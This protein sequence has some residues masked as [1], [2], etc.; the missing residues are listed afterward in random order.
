MK[1]IEQEAGQEGVERYMGEWNAG[2]FDGWGFFKEGDGGKYLGQF[3]N[4]RRHGMGLMV[5]D[6]AKTKNAMRNSN[7]KL[8][9]WEHDKE[10]V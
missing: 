5:Q 10:I 8:T 3:K 6:N 1:W 9:K 4:D 2:S 7:Q